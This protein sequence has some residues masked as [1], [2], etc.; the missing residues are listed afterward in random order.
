MLENGRGVPQDFAEAI[1]NY[2]I[3]CRAGAATAC[4]R[5]AGL[6]KAGAD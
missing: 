3:A 6:R 2:D 1:A 4:D 5:A